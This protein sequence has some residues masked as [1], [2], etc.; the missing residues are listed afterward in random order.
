VKFGRSVDVSLSV[1]VRISFLSTV[2][3]IRSIRERLQQPARRAPAAVIWASPDLRHGLAA[4]NTDRS[5]QRPSGAPRAVSSDK[6]HQQRLWTVTNAA[7]SE[8]TSGDLQRI[9]TG[10]IRWRPKGV[11]RA[12]L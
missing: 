6:G 9:R 7:F 5:L 8:S 12:L 2:P 1:F 11:G 10:K 4:E 3:G